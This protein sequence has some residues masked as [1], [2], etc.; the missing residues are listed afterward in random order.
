MPVTQMAHEIR[1]PVMTGPLRRAQQAYALHNLP[2]EHDILGGIVDANLQ[3]SE[4]G[5]T[6]PWDTRL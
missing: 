3:I 4:Q 6:N 1:S 5:I 2:D